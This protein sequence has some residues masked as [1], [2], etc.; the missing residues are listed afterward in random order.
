MREDIRKI[1]IM[2]AADCVKSM[3][4]VIPAAIV[5]PIL[6]QFIP[7]GYTLWERVETFFIVFIFSF[8]I[9]ALF[10]LM[11]MLFNG[12][13]LLTPDGIRKPGGMM[14]FYDDFDTV[15]VTVYEGSLHLYFQE[16]DVVLMR[17]GGEIG[18][19]GCYRM[20][21]GMNEVLDCLRAMGKDVRTQTV[22]MSKWEEIYMSARKCLLRRRRFPF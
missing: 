11:P 19:I 21:D 20:T 12:T 18:R 14:F 2:T 10:S 3:T 7:I 17:D 13:V 6:C 9:I 5:F 15:D 8:V 4:E 1:K 16:P 22:M